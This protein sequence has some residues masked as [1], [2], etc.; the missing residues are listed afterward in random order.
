MYNIIAHY[1]HSHIVGIDYLPDPLSGFGIFNFENIF[2]N[3]FSYDTHTLNNRS[4]PQGSARIVVASYL[5]PSSVSVHL[6][7]LY[8]EGSLCVNSVYCAGSGIDIKNS[9]LVISTFG[10]KTNNDYEDEYIK[11]RRFIRSINRINYLQYINFDFGRST[12]MTFTLNDEYINNEKLIRV[13]LRRVER[14]LDS[15]GVDYYIKGKEYGDLNN[16]LHY[17]IVAINCPYIYQDKINKVWGLSARNVEL[18]EIEDY[19]G[20]IVGGVA[21][22]VDYVKKGVN[23]QFSRAFFK[24]GLLRN[25]V[26]YTVY[27]DKATLKVV[28]HPVFGAYITKKDYKIFRGRL[29]VPELALLE[30]YNWKDRNK[31]FYYYQRLY[32]EVLKTTNE[33]GG[34]G[35]PV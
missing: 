28:P 30:W 25:D 31:D 22:L 27:Y 6:E 14:Y 8:A 18:Q 33:G 16:R 17:H 10:V 19:K 34:S 4:F 5:P 20:G 1:I 12:A 3:Y 32:N 9:N 13:R 35:F 2:I 15:L 21:Y 26:Y 29:S 11:K 7:V 23:L 24:E